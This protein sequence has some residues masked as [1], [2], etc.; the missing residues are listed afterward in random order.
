MSFFCTC[1]EKIIYSIRIFLCEG[2]FSNWSSVIGILIKSRDAPVEKVQEMG[3]MLDLQEESVNISDAE[4]ENE[5]KT[6]DQYL[7]KPLPNDEVELTKNNQMLTD[8]SINMAQNILS[9][10]FKTRQCFQDT[11]LEQRVM[12]QDKE[13]FVQILHNNNF[14]W[15]IV[16]NLNSKHGTIY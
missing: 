11:V 12:F 16:S 9:R 13:Q 14:H 8:V 3:E 1:I 5:K 2:Y 4:N 15:V 7:V 6:F 10:Q